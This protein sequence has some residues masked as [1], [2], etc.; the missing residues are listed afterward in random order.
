MRRTDN[1]LW[2][3]HTQKGVDKIFESNSE[4]IK[5]NQNPGNNQNGSSDNPKYGIPNSPGVQDF[6]DKFEVLGH[7]N[8]KV[9]SVAMEDGGTYWCELKGVSNHTAQV[10]VVGKNIYH[11][12]TSVL[13]I[14]KQC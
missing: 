5:A 1:L 8:L 6:K 7:Y 4:N 14:Q 9:K 3:R 2:W 10:T 12:L 13:P 11:I